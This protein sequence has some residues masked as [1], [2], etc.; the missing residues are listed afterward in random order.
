MRARLHAC[1][2]WYLGWQHPERLLGVAT[3]GVSP[4]QYGSTHYYATHIAISH[5][6]LQVGAPAGDASSRSAV[7]AIF[8]GLL[9]STIRFQPPHGHYKPST[10]IQ[11]F[12]MLHLDIAGNEISSLEDAL[13]HHSVPESIGE[14]KE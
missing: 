13:R 8:G 12:N 10:T 3:T 5:L 2:L 14:R 11:S 1:R 4:Y 7:S 9:K 6:L